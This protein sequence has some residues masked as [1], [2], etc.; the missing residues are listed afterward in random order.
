M[1]LTEELKKSPFFAGVGIKEKTLS[2]QL[3]EIERKKKVNLAKITAKRKSKKKKVI[4]IPKAKI[5]TRKTARIKAL[6]KETIEVI[7][8]YKKGVSNKRISGLTKLTLSAVYSIIYK[9]NSNYY[10]RHLEKLEN[11][12]KK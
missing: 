10:D 2:E 6:K 7:E 9:Y 3:K 11:E 4:E 5:L 1:Q 8:L 12:G